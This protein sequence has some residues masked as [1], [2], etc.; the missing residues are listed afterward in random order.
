MLGIFWD[1]YQQAQIQ[2]LQGRERL[3]Q[4]E[5][6]FA[7]RREAQRQVFDLA[8]RVEKLTLVAHAMWTLLSERTNISEEDLL[9]KITEI[10][11][12]DGAVDG[13]VA[14]APVKCSCGATVCARFQRCLFCGKEYRSGSAFA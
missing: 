12:R 5:V 3:E 2:D 13:K 6:Q 7:A 10:D 8:D 11:G 4:S 9:R 14:R 1:L